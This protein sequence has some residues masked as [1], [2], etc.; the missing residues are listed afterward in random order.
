MQRSDGTASA[1]PFLF[2]LA[3]LV[4]VAVTRVAMTYNVFGQTFDEPAHV[5]CGVEIVSTGRYTLEPQHPPLARLAIGLAA[6]A[7]LP[8]RGTVWQR[9]NLILYRGGEYVHN[10]AA[11]RAG[12]LP[13]LAVTIVLTWSWTRRLY[14]DVPALVAA[15]LVST[16]PALL[17]HA[18]LATTDAA[19]AAMTLL[20]LDRFSRWLDALT[21][22]NALLL[23][24]ACALAVTSK[25]SALLF[26]PAGFV[27][28]ALTRRRP[29]LHR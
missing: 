23:G 16:T 10:L 27:A 14:G 20:A 17:A 29:P 12:I 6:H 3:A 15:L 8:D 7:P 22:R 18:G 2:V 21:P 11:A 13:F 28:I 25:F 9:G 4:L 19:V 24:A 26:L 1:V 5:A